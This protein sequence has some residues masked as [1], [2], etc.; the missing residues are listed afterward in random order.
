MADR[1]APGGDGA[2]V[3]SGRR[4]LRLYRC[5]LLTPAVVDLA[6]TSRT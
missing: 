6:G 3:L 5:P 4:E 1:L 2:C